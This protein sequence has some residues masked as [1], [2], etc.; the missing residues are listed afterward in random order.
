[1]ASEGVYLI[2]DNHM[3]KTMGALIVIALSAGSR[4]YAY[5]VPKPQNSKLAARNL[6]QSVL[7]RCLVCMSLG[8]ERRGVR[9]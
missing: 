2:M 3:E 1:M 9:T 4:V 7:G 8:C 6:P 5:R